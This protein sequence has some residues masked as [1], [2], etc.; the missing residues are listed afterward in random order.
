MPE[1]GYLCE[2]APKF[3]SINILIRK[4]SPN[5]KI[6]LRGDIKIQEAATM[7]IA[8]LFANVSNISYSHF[9]KYFEL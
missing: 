3:M 2:A 7:T 5:F 6:A 4:T 8:Q 1:A 9:L